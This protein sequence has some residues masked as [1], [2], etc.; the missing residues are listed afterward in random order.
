M[1]IKGNVALPRWRPE[2]GIRVAKAVPEE[3]KTIAPSV[4]EPRPEMLVKGTVVLPKWRPDSELARRTAPVEADQAAPR[5]AVSGLVA[6]PRWRPGAK[7]RRV[8]QDG[9]GEVVKVA[10]S[11]AYLIQDETRDR[12]LR[13]AALPTW[14]PDSG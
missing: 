5:M 1:A 2:T 6:I 12:P 9:A 3:K 10:G 8:V 11:S 4:V 14:R 13:R 7:I